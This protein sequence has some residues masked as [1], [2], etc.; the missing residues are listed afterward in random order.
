MTANFFCL[1]N[2]SNFHMAEG[3]LYIEAE[4]SVLIQKEMFS[5]SCEEQQDMKSTEGPQQS[6]W[7]PINFY[8]AIPESSRG[9]KKNKEENNNRIPPHHKAGWN[10]M[11]ISRFSGKDTYAELEDWFAT[12]TDLSDVIKVLCTNPYAWL[13][14]SFCFW[15]I[16]DFHPEYLN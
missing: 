1:H 6:V 7:W 8:W 2:Q 11:Y 13:L 16:L 4:T 3:L 9:L 10:N 5:E 12:Y 14:S 15:N